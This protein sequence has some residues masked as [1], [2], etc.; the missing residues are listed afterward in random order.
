[1]LD[2]LQ[3]LLTYI[4]INTAAMWRAT[5]L[6]ALARNQGTPAVPPEALD[7]DMILAAQADGVGAIVVTANAAH[8][9]PFIVARHWRD[10]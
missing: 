4:P 10:F 9:S 5:Q 7:A 1:L 6:W 3:E 8:L 2:T